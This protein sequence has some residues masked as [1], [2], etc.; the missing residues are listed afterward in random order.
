[1]EIS[2][3]KVFNPYNLT[4]T[5]S[6]VLVLG[7]GFKYS[8]TPP[9][10]P[11][12][13]ATSN[14]LDTLASFKRKLLLS[15]Y[16]SDNPFPNNEDPN[17]PISPTTSDWVPD[18][19]YPNDWYVPLCQ[20][21]KEC[22]Q[23]IKALSLSTLRRTLDKVVCHIASALGRR[24]DIVIKP[25]DKNLGVI[26]LP[27]QVYD[28]L[29][30]L[31]LQDTSTYSLVTDNSFLDHSYANLT[32]ILSDHNKL[33]KNPRKRGFDANPSPTK[34][35][36][37]LLQRQGMSLQNNL[38][39]FYCL[40]K[41]H[42]SPLLGR[43]IVSCVRSLSYYS[44]VY[45]HNALQSILSW[46]PE[47]CSGSR[48]LLQ[49]VQP[50]IRPTGIEPL[51]L[52]TKIVCA[53]VTSLYPSINIDF[54]LAV[55]KSLIQQYLGHLSAIDQSFLLCLLEWVLKNNYFSFG[56]CY[57]LQLQGTAMGTPVAV[58]YAQLVLTVHDKK[59]T[60]LHSPLVYKRY[61]DDLFIVINCDGEDAN[62]SAI[63]DT[64]NSVHHS[65]QLSAVTIGVQGV[66]LDFEFHLNPSAVYPNEFDLAHTLYEKPSNNH[67]Y[68]PFLSAHPRHM[69][70]NFI[71]NEVNRIKL[72][73]SEQ[74]GVGV[75]IDR[76]K[77]RLY[78]RGYP[79][80]FV[81]NSLAL[82]PRKK[83]KLL[84]TPPVFI[85]SLP[86]LRSRVSFK[87][88]LQPPPSLLSSSSYKKAFSSQHPIVAKS[89]DYK[90]G[91]FFLHPKSDGKVP[92]QGL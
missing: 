76:F 28:N 52:S 41:V 63:V 35:A 54:G 88:L 5:Y 61:I 37:C 3:I 23:R 47:I 79:P 58:V 31:H 43:P 85:H 33:Y 39:L 15:L 64:F 90:L 29:C 18:P 2:N 51:P 67:L 69:L 72:H 13:R 26:V 89:L 49:A 27:K 21:V 60:E 42:K 11:S 7:L 45:L 92:K 91:T 46:F 4:L 44:S 1:M 19:T 20:Y 57:Y 77:Q 78:L 59:C 6:E 73:C 66:F 74:Q 62:P 56:G 84:K 24:K 81:A 68:I 30:H 38:G 70:A 86:S 65:L 40:P 16:F 71:R 53:D 83:N 80:T 75:L 8:F 12:S 48:D 9:S 82:V 10:Y 25:A 22:Q 87:E 32:S 36:K 34:L 55:I 14:L 50:Y 17:I